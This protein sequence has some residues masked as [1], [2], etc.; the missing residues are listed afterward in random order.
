MQYFG[1]IFGAFFGVIW[2]TFQCSAYVLDYKLYSVLFDELGPESTIDQIVNYFNLNKETLREY[3]DY[4][5]FSDHERN[6]MKNLTKSMFE[7]GYDNYMKYAY[8]MDE[9][10]P[11]HCK[12]RGPDYMNP[13]NI[14][15]NDALGDYLLSLVE[16]MTTLAVMGNSTEFQKA[17]KLVIQHL[18]FD[19]N[20][21]VQVF[22]STIR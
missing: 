12:G 9:L 14:N 18:S 15:V 16:S 6:R 20:N 17:V 13:G 21:T 4:L 2:C 11:I 8:P 22:E 10:D 3:N 5:Y 7:F 1:N 19:K